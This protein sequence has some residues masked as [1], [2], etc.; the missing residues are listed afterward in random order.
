LPVPPVRAF[1][2][3]ALRRPLTHHLRRGPP[4]PRRGDR[5]HVAVGL[6]LGERQRDRQALQDPKRGG[7]DVEIRRWSDGANFGGLSI[8]K[9]GIGPG[10]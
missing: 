9:G 6:G 2:L 1:G 7:A 4:G 10:M 8:G 5:Y 3:Q